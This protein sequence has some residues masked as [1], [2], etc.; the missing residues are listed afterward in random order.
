MKTW[1]TAVCDA[2]GDAIQCSVNGSTSIYLEREIE[3]S[4]YT[5]ADLR[6]Q[7]FDWHFGC[8][9]RMVWRDDHWDKLYGDGWFRVACTVPGQWKRMVPDG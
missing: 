8:E 2:H 4:E 6:R 3:G 5:E 1:Y 9:L 7:W